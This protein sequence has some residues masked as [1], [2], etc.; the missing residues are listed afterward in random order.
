MSHLLRSVE[1]RNFRSIKG[2]VLAPLDA[3][4][5]LVHGENGAGKTSLLSAIELSLTGKVQSLQRADENYGQQ[6]LFRGSEAGL[7]RTKVLSGGSTY[8][9]QTIIE[10]AGFSD[11]QNLDLPLSNFFTERS[12]LPQS[13]LSQLLQIYQESSSGMDSPLA[14]FV[15]DLLGL[16]R[17]DAI[18]AGLQPA[19]DV[20][21][22]RKRSPVWL[23]KESEVD[24]LERERIRAETEEQRL[25]EEFQSLISDLQERL[26]VLGIDTVASE[27]NYAATIEEALREPHDT[28]LRDMIVRQ[29][30][31]SAIREQINSTHLF[32]QGEYK[33]KAS[34]LEIALAKNVRWQA[35]NGT[36]LEEIS[37]EFFGLLPDASLESDI[38]KSWNQ[39]IPYLQS[40]KNRVKSRLEMAREDERDI[41]SLEEETAKARASIDSIKIEL[42]NI[43][44]RADGLASVISEIS[45]FVDGDRCPVCDRNFSEC[46]DVSLSDHVVQKVRDLSS[47]AE[48]L[49]ALGRSL[50]SHE[51]VLQSNEQKLEK[52]KSRS[53]S[54]EDFNRLDRRAASLQNLASKMEEFSQLAR[55]GKELQSNEISRRRDLSEF[56]AM[57]IEISAAQETLL[58]FS[59]AVGFEADPSSSVV[60]LASALN[61]DLVGREENLRNLSRA[62]DR[63]RELKDS[64]DRCRQNQKKHGEDKAAIQSELSI[65]TSSVERGSRVRRQAN[66]LREEIDH[67]RSGI[68]RREFNDRLNLLWRDLFVRL[69]P[70][71][72][73]VPAFSV[74]EQKTHRLEPKLVTRFRDGG[75]AGGTPGAMLS[76]GNLNTAALTLFLALHLSVPKQLPWLILDDPVQSMD[77]LHIS[78]FASL[79]RTLSKEHGRQII[80]AV[81]DRQ[82]F[83]YLALELSPAY[84]DDSLLTL[85]MSRGANKDSRCVAHRVSYK[86][87]TSLG[88]VA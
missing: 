12:F 31:L 37:N 79:L 29:R 8:P 75:D 24:R 85:E 69:A 73:F 35:D 32:T 74:P 16:D 6:I 1:V 22:V 13:L 55:V 17:L 3:N 57:E 11:K 80:I 38:L 67:V 48:R 41:A 43:P 58:E 78:N 84:P 64:L 86:H 54:S 44:G 7:V 10:Q 88:E 60:A 45:A 39:A 82:L 59:R 76:A 33:A 19:K 28:F 34:A 46:S 71:E 50:N 66:D 70:N 30:E 42:E 83:D 52:I 40:E 36:A 14:Q 47:F 65:V 9:Y 68:I 2:R 61:D 51:A 4:V 27:K 18:E 53:L 21:N 26:L 25:S 49:L 87:D 63:V 77:D 81:H 20:R 62:Q 15:G 5:V 56:R 23:E 72:P